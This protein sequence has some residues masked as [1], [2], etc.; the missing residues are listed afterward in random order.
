[1]LSIRETHWLERSIKFLFAG[2]NSV[3]FKP[4]KNVL[5]VSF[6]FHW[7]IKFIQNNEEENCFNKAIPKEH[8]KYILCLFDIQSNS[9]NISTPQSSV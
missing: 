2:V 5:P 6:F 1:M 4:N 7:N 9:G 8:S 3:F